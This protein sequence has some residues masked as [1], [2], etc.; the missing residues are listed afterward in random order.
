[1]CIT[2]FY[3]RS[4][5]V[6]TGEIPFRGVP[7]S[8]LGYAVVHGKRPDKP[9]N[10]SA[11]G[12]SDSLWNFAQRCWDGKIELRP[13]VGEVITHLREAAANWDGRMPE[14]EL[15]PDPPLI[16]LTGQRCRRKHPTVPD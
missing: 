14:R 5:Q 6:L 16:L 13:K 15:D 10:A 1:M 4:L 12:F 2:Y 11:I 8:A 3:V 9:E 7:Q